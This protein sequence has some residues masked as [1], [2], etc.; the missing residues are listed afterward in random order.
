MQPEPIIRIRNC[1]VR[2]LQTRLHERDQAVR[3][4]LWHVGGPVALHAVVGRGGWCG[5]RAVFEGDAP[6]AVGVE[7][8][9][10]GGG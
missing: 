3:A 7:V 9:G 4:W 2:P 10:F 5:V 6:R 8:S 1:A